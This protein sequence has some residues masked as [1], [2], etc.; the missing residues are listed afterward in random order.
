[1]ALTA[2]IGQPCVVQ[3]LFVDGNNHPVNV[4]NPRCT[5]FY[6][7]VDGNKQMVADDQP[8]VGVGAEVGRFRYIFSVP[9]NL[10][11]GDSLY[12][13]MTA[14]DEALAGRYFAEQQLT[15]VVQSTSNGTMRT[16]FVRGG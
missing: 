1:M 3:T 11:A 4:D 10:N 16:Q 7:D 5:V 14:T 13:E 15:A 6:L 9:G 2:I 12:A 8:M